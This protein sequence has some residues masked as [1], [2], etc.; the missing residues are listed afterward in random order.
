MA[1]ASQSHQYMALDE[2]NRSPA[3]CPQPSQSVT[4]YTSTYSSPRCWEIPVTLEKVVCKGAFGQV[5][6][7]TVIGLQGKPTKT[8]VAVKML[9]GIKYFK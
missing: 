9:K 7:A 2:R 5:A 1:E 8:L 6:K 3:N 4:A